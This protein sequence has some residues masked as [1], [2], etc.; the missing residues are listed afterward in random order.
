MI[1][2]V[3]VDSVFSDINEGYAETFLP[4]AVIEAGQ[5]SASHSRYLFRVRNG[6]Y[7]VHPEVLNS[8][9]KDYGVKERQG[10]DAPWRY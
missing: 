9:N 7:R 5:Y 8:G 1:Q 10:V 6:V 4:A 2:E 3:F